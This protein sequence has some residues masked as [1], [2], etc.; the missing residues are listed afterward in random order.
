MNMHSPGAIEATKVMGCYLVQDSN[1][2]VQGGAEGLLQVDKL[3]HTARSAMIGEGGTDSKPDRSA[4]AYHLIK[5]GLLSQ[6]IDDL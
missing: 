5:V 1:L 3:Q 4:C 6:G 2:L